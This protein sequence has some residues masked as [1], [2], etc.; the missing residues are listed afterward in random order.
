MKKLSEKPIAFVAPVIIGL[1][2]AAILIK[3]RSPLEHAGEQMPAR[4]VEVIIAKAIPFRGRI[5]AFGNVEPA[6]SLQTRAEVRGKVSYVHPDLKQGSSM[7]VGTLAVR[8][9]SEDYEVSLKQTEADLRSSQAS[10]KQLIEE[11]KTAKRSLQLAQENLG[12]GRNELKRIQAVY[13][14]GLVAKSSVDAEQQRV[15]QLEQQVSELQGQLNTFASRKKAE[16]SRSERYEQQVK[17]QQT[18]L[19]RTEIL[20]PFN[21][22]IGKVDIEKGAF[23]NV[24]DRLF[25]AF[26]I[27]AVEINAQLPALDMETLVSHLEGEIL[28]AGQPLSTQDMIKALQLEVRVRLVGGMPNTYWVA[29]ALRISESV[30]PTRRTLGIVVAVDNPYEKVIPTK[31]P[32]L[33]KGMYTAVELIAPASTAIVIPRKAIHQGRVYVAD[34][35]DKLVIKPV[36]IK[37]VQ[38]NIAVVRS[39]LAPDERVILTDLIPVIEGM[40]LAP[41][42]AAQAQAKL[43]KLASGEI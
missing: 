35:N 26:D 21:A 34:Q 2:I 38:G 40:P 42:H 31:R 5:T 19:G 9:D 43:I 41:T 33:I 23:V 3:S 10:Q 11:E 22:R 32:P 24:G 27:K 15:I 29:K 39:G 7:N 18:T 4:N 30:D 14:K 16:T 12:V 36:D 28:S 13:E 6:V 25:E 1:I 20:M 17:G 8:V 37:I